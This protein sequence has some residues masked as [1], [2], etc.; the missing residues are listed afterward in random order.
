MRVFWIIR[1]SWMFTRIKP[2]PRYDIINH[3]FLLKLNITLSQ[4]LKSWKVSLLLLFRVSDHSQR[5]TKLAILE[6]SQNHLSSEHGAVQRHICQFNFLSTFDSLLNDEHSFQWNFI[7][8]SSF[9]KQIYCSKTKE[10]FRDNLFPENLQI[11]CLLFKKKG[12]KMKKTLLH[13]PVI[14]TNTHYVLWE[15]GPSLHLFCIKY[16]KELNIF[17][18]ILK[19]VKTKI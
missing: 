2:W 19:K 18:K 13:P 12:W 17:R 15:N 9:F 3:T 4:T 6:K 10:L 11:L 5:L 16:G 8:M 14:V 7:W 1:L